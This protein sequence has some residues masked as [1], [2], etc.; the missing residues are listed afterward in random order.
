MRRPEEVTDSSPQQKTP[1]GVARL[2]SR[3]HEC[4]CR[5]SWWSF[6]SPAVTSLPDTVLKINRATLM[7]KR[8]HAQ[9]LQWCPTLRDPMD[10]GPPGS[11]VHGILRTRTLEWAAV[12]SSGGSSRPRD[13]SQGFCIAGRFLTTSRTWD[14]PS[15]GQV[16]VVTGG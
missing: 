14:V 11:S 7:G 12:P 9:S 2:P 8:V 1:A 3:G 5:N 6:S 16:P 4:G 10:C 15:G 13:R